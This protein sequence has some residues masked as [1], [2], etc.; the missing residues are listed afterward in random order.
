MLLLVLQTVLCLLERS[1]LLSADLFCQSG[2]IPSLQAVPSYQGCLLG[3]GNGHIY[4]TSCYLL[5]S[6]MTEHGT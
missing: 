5:I 2:T 1:V 4:F 6:V 3:L